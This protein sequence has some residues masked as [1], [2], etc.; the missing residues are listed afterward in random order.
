M[1][2]K[3]A[4]K[5]LRQSTIC[6]VKNRSTKRD[7][8]TRMKRV[9]EALEAGNADEAQQLFRQATKKLDQAAAHRIIHP[10]AAA[11]H[12]SRMAARV[13]AGTEKPQAKAEG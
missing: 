1:H 6:R 4:A 2:T 3:S 10:N 9:D 7:L 8:H 13:K 12:K 5:R 11:R